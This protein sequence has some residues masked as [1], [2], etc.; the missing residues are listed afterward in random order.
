MYDLRN[1]MNTRDS[2]FLMR[3]GKDDKNFIEKCIEDLG[4]TIFDDE[5]H[6]RENFETTL[7]GRFGSFHFCEK[8]TLI[9]NI[10]LGGKLSTFDQRT[11]Y[12]IS[13]FG[14]KILLGPR[15]ILKIDESLNPHIITFT[16]GNLEFIPALILT[17]TII[18]ES[19][20]IKLLDLK[21]FESD[22]FDSHGPQIR[23]ILEAI[24]Q[25]AYFEHGLTFGKMTEPLFECQIFQKIKNDLF[26]WD[27]SKLSD[28]Q[29][30]ALKA[31]GENVWA[32]ST[33]VFDENGQHWLEQN[34][35]NDS[36]MPSSFRNL[37][38]STTAEKNLA[39]QFVLAENVEI[40]LIE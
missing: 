26:V 16:T 31:L 38:L 29:F 10:V 24:T 28:S 12:P 6:V 23:K 21:K 20:T 11:G 18:T 8:L 25:K 13:Q 40:K 35:W 39:K 14:D 32:Y 3:L 33:R 4:K 7:F 30:E 5:F 9:E 37:H 1:K 2:V 15:D 34:P 17:F 19:K 36:F 27:N 22:T